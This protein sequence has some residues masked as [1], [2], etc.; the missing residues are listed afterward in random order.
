MTDL[1]SRKLF[2][3]QL[4]QCTQG[5]HE[6][7]SVFLYKNVPFQ[8]VWIQGTVI[9]YE[10]TEE[11]DNPVYFLDDSTGVIEVRGTQKL[12][13]KVQLST[14]MYILVVGKVLWPAGTER[15][16]IA[17]HQVVDLSS[18]ENRESLWMLEVVDVSSKFY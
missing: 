8:R 4:L 17:S 1:C 16:V 10:N 13:I 5:T 3:S 7:K 15:P 12:P 2:I 14:G 11:A 9:G 6:G 18:E